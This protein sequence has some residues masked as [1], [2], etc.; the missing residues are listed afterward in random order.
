MDQG[1]IQ[2]TQIATQC[3]RFRQN[4]RVVS[5]TKVYYVEAH[6]FSAFRQNAS[7]GAGRG[8]A[9]CDWTAKD[10]VQGRMRVPSRRRR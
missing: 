2:H 8:S 10:V 3:L 4:R 7:G 5:K 9:R 6:T 1:F